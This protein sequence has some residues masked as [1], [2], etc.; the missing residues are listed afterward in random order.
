[1][2]RNLLLQLSLK[3]EGTLCMIAQGISSSARL[4]SD[5]VSRLQN[6]GFAEAGDDVVTLT[7]LG[8]QRFAIVAR[9]MMSRH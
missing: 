2:P 4:R 8:V 6:L 9:A 1:M 5:D 3:E 7:P